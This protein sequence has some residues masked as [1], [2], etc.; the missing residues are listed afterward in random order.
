[1]CQSLA[2]QMVKRINGPNGSRPALGLAPVASPLVPGS[3]R[4]TPVGV[5]TTKTN[6]PSLKVEQTVTAGK[7]LKGQQVQFQIA[8]SNTG[9]GPARNVSVQTK[10]SPGLR[11]KPGEPND[12]NLFEQTLDRIE[13]GQRIMLDP[14][15]ADT[16]MAGEQTGQVV[17]QSIDVTT[18]REDARSI[19]SVTVIEPRLKLA[20]T[21]DAKRFTNTLATYNVTIEN[22]GTA[23]AHNVRVLATL[24]LTGRLVGPPPSGAS[25]DASSG[26]L[27]WTI[28]QLE[29]GDETKKLQLSFKVRMGGV[30][31][32]QVTVEARADGGLFDTASSRTDV[33]GLA[34][35]ESEFVEDRRIIDIEDM[36]KFTIRVKN[37]GTKDATNLLV[38]ALL[39]KNIEPIETRNGTGDRI[40]AQFNP[41]QQMLVFPPIDRLGPSKEVVLGIKVK[42]SAKGLGTC[43]VFLIHDEL[44][45]GEHF[46][47]M[48]AFRI[49]APAEEA[50]TPAVNWRAAVV[51]RP[52]A[53]Y[54]QGRS[55]HNSGNGPIKES[56]SCHRL[57][58]CWLIRDMLAAGRV[59]D[60][61]DG[62]ERSVP[63][64]HLQPVER[65]AS[66]P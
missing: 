17:A 63:L 59:A 28:S 65:G 54:H 19:A 49:T 42:A 62:D 60:R 48:A 41:A 2:A 50:M 27:V 64:V 66:R 24:P 45:D 15:V 61:L 57:W 14:L 10:L 38:R 40:Q 34:D 37:I 7:V 20:I 29:P 35:I 8:I 58:Q 43:R 26:K 51:L 36:D 30:G 13:P 21:G 5:A 46:E 16:L 39:S 47:N 53:G 3:L 9:T 22:P 56:S 4:A 52:F 23:T 32:C 33:A 11:Y 31:L 18:G 44:D 25:W 6:A 55:T 1:M 12:Q